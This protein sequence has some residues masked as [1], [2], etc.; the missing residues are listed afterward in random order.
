MGTDDPT[1]YLSV[2]K[3]IDWV[4]NLLGNGWEEL[5]RKNRDLVLQARQIICDQLQLNLPCP[6]EMIGS[7]ASIPLNTLFTGDNLSAQLL[8]DQLLE[9]FQ[10]EI[11]IIPFPSEQDKIMRISAQ[12]YNS[13]DEYIY[14]ADVIKEDL[15]FN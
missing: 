7:M 2:A 1:A 15:I 8:Q 6:D 11:P 10:I 4:E 5:R 13:I 12:L 3:A 9:Q 14:L